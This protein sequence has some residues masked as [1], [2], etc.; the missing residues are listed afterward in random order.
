[1][2]HRL[3][4]LCLAVAALSLA[5]LSRPVVAQEQPSRELV[6]WKG[7]AAGTS[8]AF[9]IPVDPPIVVVQFTATGESNMLGPST[10]VG[11]F[12]MRVG[13]DGLPLSATDGIYAETSAGGDAIY[14]TFSGLIRA[15]EKPGFIVLEGVSLITGGKGRFAG[16]AGHDRLR[17]ESELATGKGSFSWEGLISRPK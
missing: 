17:S 12:L 4:T 10:T 16:A 13:A 2:R 5:T 1:M 11:Y 14:G 15:S 3:S 8:S 6:T 7:T 9:I